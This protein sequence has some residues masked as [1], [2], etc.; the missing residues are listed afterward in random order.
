MSIQGLAPSILPSNL[1]EVIVNQ[2]KVLNEPID[3]RHE[4]S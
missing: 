3:R 4:P 2:A 1:E